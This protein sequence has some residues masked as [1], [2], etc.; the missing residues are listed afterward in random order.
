M[1]AVCT[2]RSCPLG[3][4]L[5]FFGR[6]LTSRINAHVGGRSNGDKTPQ[7]PQLQQRDGGIELPMSS[8]GVCDHEA[9]YSGIWSEQPE[10]PGSSPSFP[11]CQL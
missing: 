5:G 3:C 11:D 4:R 9:G 6:A 2:P 7:S 10:C 8:W 1:G